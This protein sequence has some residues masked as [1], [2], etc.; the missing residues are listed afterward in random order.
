MQPTPHD[1]QGTRTV[2][3]KINEKLTSSDETYEEE[4][5]FSY[6]VEWLDNEENQ[7][8]LR[9]SADKRLTA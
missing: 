4:Y 6:I 9:S 7:N 8:E 3:N 2:F 1:L 5:P